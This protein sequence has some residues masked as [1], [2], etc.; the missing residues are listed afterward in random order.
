MYRQAG[1]TGYRRKS[2]KG[3]KS[4]LRARAATVPDVVEKPLR[5]GCFFV[6]CLL[7]TQEDVPT[8]RAERSRFFV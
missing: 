8:G 6:L 1:R 2:E 5:E 3:R 7:G 4:A